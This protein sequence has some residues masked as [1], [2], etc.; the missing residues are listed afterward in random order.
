MS[1]KSS[2]DEFASKIIVREV[3][4][5]DLDSSMKHLWASLAQ[6]MFEIEPLT[7]PSETNSGKWLDFVK[8]G[9]AKRHNILMAAKFEEK[10][11]GYALL[12][13]PREQA[14]EVQETFG[15][16]NELYVVPEFRKKRHWKEPSGRKPG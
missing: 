1:A 14:F 7:L 12:T 11:V 4:V 15:I 5:E 9:L 16:V 13:L 6:E 8:E 2:E 10:T 3:G